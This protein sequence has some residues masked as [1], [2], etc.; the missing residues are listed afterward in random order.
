MNGRSWCLHQ[1]I[2]DK[3]DEYELVRSDRKYETK[4]KQQFNPREKHT[5]S[6]QR[7]VRHKPFTGT[8]NA[9]NMGYPSRNGESKQMHKFSCYS[10]GLE[11]H[12]ARIFPLK[13]P[14]RGK[15]NPTALGNVI[16]TTEPKKENPF[17]VRMTLLLPKLLY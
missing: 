10:C 7:T 1:N 9:R 6:N 16:A 15:L 11:G 17:A 3:L 8:W 14:Q 12:T 2:A 4:W 13:A 5:E